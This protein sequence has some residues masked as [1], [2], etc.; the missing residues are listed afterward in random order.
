MVETAW[1]DI[2]T[3]GVEKIQL[4]ESISLQELV[5]LWML[6]AGLLLTISCM[7][8]RWHSSVYSNARFGGAAN[9][10]FFY[11]FEQNSTRLAAFKL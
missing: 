10:P 4:S 2:A 6:A 3:I 7:G 9:A 8:V 5:I 1:L 11:L